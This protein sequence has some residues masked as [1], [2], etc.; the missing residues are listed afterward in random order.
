MPPVLTVLL[1]SAALVA[2]SL[3]VAPVRRWVRFG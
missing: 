2:A 1:I 3:L